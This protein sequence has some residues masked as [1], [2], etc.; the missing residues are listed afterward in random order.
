MS[1]IFLDSSAVICLVQRIE[2]AFA[3]ITKIEAESGGGVVVSALAVTECLAG[4]TDV[5]LRPRFEAFFA[6]QNVW[7]I[8]ADFSICRRAA[9][10][11]TQARLKTPDAIHLAT[12]EFARTPALVTTDRD[13][14]AATQSTHVLIQIIDRQPT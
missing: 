1:M 14:D 13:F 12:A 8:P 11:R 5:V 4:L 10:I 3:E 6:A 9:E 2:P 7:V